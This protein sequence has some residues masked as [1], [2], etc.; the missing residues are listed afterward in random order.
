MFKGW[1]QEE[2]EV[3]VNRRWP[4]GLI[5]SKLYPLLKK[6]QTKLQNTPQSI[7]KRYKIQMN[8]PWLSKIKIMVRVHQYLLKK[9]LLLIRKKPEMLNK[10]FK[11]YKRAITRE[12]N[13]H[14]LRPYRYRRTPYL[15]KNTGC[16]KM[17]GRQLSIYFPK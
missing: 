15:I 13:A 7:P 17:N 4:F 10:V 2:P 3:P 12:Y 11:T 6:V 14:N 5:S 1:I 8:C 16:Q 9:Y